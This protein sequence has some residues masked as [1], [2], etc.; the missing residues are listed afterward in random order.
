MRRDGLLETGVIDASSRDAAVVLI[1]SRG[2][3]AIEVV[4]QSPALQARLRIDGVDLALGLRALATL[5]R[6]GVPI[7]P[8]P[9]IMQ[10]LS[11]P[12]WRPALPAVRPRLARAAPL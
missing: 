7:S 11:S 3:F 8:A 5:L 2:G 6:P 10:D 4:E 9:A 12:A 1:G